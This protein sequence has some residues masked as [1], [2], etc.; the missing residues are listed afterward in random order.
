V[1]FTA[2]KPNDVVVTGTNGDTY[3]KLEN[4]KFI[5]DIRVRVSVWERISPIDTNSYYYPT[6]AE[7]ESKLIK[8][9]SRIPRD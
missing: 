7:D 5:D 8:N 4:A 9:F 3:R 2:C 6:F 1:L